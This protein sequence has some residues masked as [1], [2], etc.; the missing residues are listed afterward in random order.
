MH[1]LPLQNVKMLD[2]LTNQT[3]LTA[4]TLLIFTGKLF[5]SPRHSHTIESAE[6]YTS[7]CSLHFKILNKPLKIEITVIKIIIVYTDRIV[8]ESG[9]FWR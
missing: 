1:L 4:L 6:L 9:F 8:Q 2:V 7:A 3:I 5:F